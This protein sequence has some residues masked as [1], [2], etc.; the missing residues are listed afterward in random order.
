MKKC[1]PRSVLLYPSDLRTIINVLDKYVRKMSSFY[2][3]SESNT[4][5][6]KSRTALQFE[7]S[8]RINISEKGKT[9]KKD[10]NMF[11][12]QCYEKKSNYLQQAN[13]KFCADDVK[14]R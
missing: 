10:T 13:V 6:D 4:Q 3:Y 8:P 9:I 2:K 11:V 14:S 12:F 7:L 1:V 5:K